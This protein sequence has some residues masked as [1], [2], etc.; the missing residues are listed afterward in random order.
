MHK[1]ILLCLT[2]LWSNVYA[3]SSNGDRAAGIVQMTLNRPGMQIIDMVQVYEA[4]R[5]ASIKHNVPERLI[6][7]I[8]FVESSYRLNAVNRG[9]NDYGIMQVNIWHV[10]R[11]KLSIKRLTTDI[12]YSFDK[13]VEILKWFYD[14]Y[15]LDEAIMRYNCGTRP[16]CIK[17]KR[18]KKYLD[19][20]R[21]S[22]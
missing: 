6:L 4:A 20:T 8:A 2:M 5:K 22:M 3:R 14:T 7:A 1:I 13:G 17:W 10:K 12:D 16:S 11:S 18:V 21:R 19:K 9:S 15:P